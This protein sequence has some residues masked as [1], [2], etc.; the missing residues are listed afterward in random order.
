M[1]PSVQA[2]QHAS[3]EAAKRPLDA[4]KAMY[5]VQVSGRHCLWADTASNPASADSGA[6]L[7]PLQLG[8]LPQKPE[9]QAA[10]Q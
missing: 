3:C 5:Q 2:F 7:E 8:D 10:V 6:H 1:F 4:N 9:A